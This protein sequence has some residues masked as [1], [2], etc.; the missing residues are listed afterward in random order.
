M[1]A[2]TALFRAPI[3]REPASSIEPRIARLERRIIW[4]EEQIDEVFYRQVEGEAALERRA[5]S[6]ATVAA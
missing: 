6:D 1:N 4:L 2:L 5:V 3:A